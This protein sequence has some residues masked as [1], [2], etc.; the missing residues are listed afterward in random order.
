MDKVIRPPVDIEKLGV[1]QDGE[2]V[3]EE[4]GG[5]RK[6]G[7]K[8]SRKDPSGKRGLS[9]LKPRDRSQGG[10]GGLVNLLTTKNVAIIALSV[11]LAIVI[12]LFVF[13]R[14]GDALILV[15][16]DQALN[17][18]L[19]KVK[20]T[21][22]SD[23][24][25]IDNIIANYATTQSVS[26]AIGSLDL[27]GF[28]TSEELDTAIGNV[29]VS[30]NCYGYLTEAA[31]TYTLHVEANPGV[32]MARV[33]LLYPI[34][35]SLGASNISEAYGIFSSN[36]TGRAFVPEFDGTLKVVS[37]S[38]YTSTFEVVGGTW[39]GALG[40]FTASGSYKVG[41]GVLPVVVPSGSSNSSGG[42][43]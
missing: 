38:F 36:W 12:G 3:E 20:T 30:S 5:G 28:V 8:L 37:A 19:G 25:R 42:G 6:G 13:A 11:I 1:N 22:D 31:G 40:T 10:G 33:S 18:E 17:E 2:Q 14:Q 29:D 9:Y 23:T 15:K 24:K 35:H 41:V 21:Q 4:V 39:S 27:G 26:T 34:P 7:R 32:Y 43:I 16:N